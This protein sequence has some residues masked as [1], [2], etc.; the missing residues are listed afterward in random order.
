VNRLTVH[1]ENY[2]VRK[3]KNGGSEMANKLMDFSLAKRDQLLQYTKAK[4][5]MVMGRINGWPWYAQVLTSFGCCVLIGLLLWLLHRYRVEIKISYLMAQDRVS[6][7]EFFQHVLVELLVG[8][9]R[10]PSTE[11]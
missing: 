10:A 6:E 11:V 4:L 9:D 8:Q 5:R 7:L 2:N 3:P 1:G